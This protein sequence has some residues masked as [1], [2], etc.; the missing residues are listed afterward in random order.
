MLF[1]RWRPIGTARTRCCCRGNVE[2]LRSLPHETPE[3][4]AI[5]RVSFGTGLNS[6]PQSSRGVSVDPC[7]VGGYCPL[8]KGDD[9]PET[10]GP[11]IPSGLAAATCRPRATGYEA[12]LR[13]RDRGIHGPANHRPGVSVGPS[14]GFFLPDLCGAAPFSAR[15]RVG[16]SFRPLV[17]KSA[18]LI[19]QKALFGWH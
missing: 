4:Q 6:S 19:T 14:A 15:G 2:S 5:S 11:R 16:Y 7:A 18:S 10:L 9:R 17:G 12:T 3:L 8:K 1:R 13:L